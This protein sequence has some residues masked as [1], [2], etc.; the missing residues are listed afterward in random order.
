MPSTRRA[1]DKLAALRA[2]GTLNPRPQAV[3]S[4]LFQDNMFFDPADLVQVKYEMLRHVQVDH[5]P[6]AH[7]A[8]A[9]GFSR[10]AF[11]HAQLSFTQ[12]GFAGLLPQKR[13]PKGGHKLTPPV[14]AFVTAQ[15]AATPTLRWPQLAALVRQQFQLR[16]HP[17][18]LARQLEREKK[19]P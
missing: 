1:P 4:P 3:Q 6:V 10:P 11:Y 18:S 12:G 5:Q 2:Q 8:Q 7:A 15:R 9:F 13:G 16:V 17:R 14:L 19:R